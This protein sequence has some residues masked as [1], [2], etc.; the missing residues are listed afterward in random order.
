MLS[1]I[2]SWRQSNIN[3]F[4][5]FAGKTKGVKI[6]SH[7]N[8]LAFNAKLKKNQ[9]KNHPPK[10][11]KI[12]IEPLRDLDQI[13]AINRMHMENPKAK[14]GRRNNLLMVLGINNGLRAGD[15][16]R[17][18]IGQVRGLRRGD[19]IPIVEVKTGKSNSLAINR[20]SAMALDAYFDVIDYP[21]EGFLFS[22][23]KSPYAAL[24]MPSINNLIK[25]WTARIGASGNYGARTL[26]KTWGFH[27][28]VTHKVAWEL[29]SKRYNHDS[30][31]VTMRYL[32]IQDIEI[33]N[34]LLKNEIG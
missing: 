9:A 34:I 28:R 32:G 14:I 13:R 26:R 29:I 22:S 10:G 1:A 27:Q 2:F 11:S 23:Q 21:D 16:L 6:L 12:T 18:T 25:K 24:T 15:L 30:Q 19:I 3:I 31:A 4:I 7:I 8:K 17:L 33:T 5:N 20:L